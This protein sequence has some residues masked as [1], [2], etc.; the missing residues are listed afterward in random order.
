M[1]EGRRDFNGSLQ[2]ACEGV[3]EGAN[4]SLETDD[5]YA[6]SSSLIDA[7]AMIGNETL[8]SLPGATE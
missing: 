2:Y 3:R 5:G 1:S 7:R 6:L 4:E 8:L